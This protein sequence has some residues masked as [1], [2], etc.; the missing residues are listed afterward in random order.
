MTKYLFKNLMNSFI[1]I[2]KSLKIQIDVIRG[3]YYRE[4]LIRISKLRFGLIGIL[5]EPIL[6][7]SIWLL[8]FGARR[9]FEP[10]FSLDLIIFLSVGNIIYQIFASISRRSINSINA[11]EALFYYPRVKPFDTICARAL[12]EINTY[13]ILYLVIVLGYFYFK[14]IFFIDNLPLILIS[15]L[16][17]SIL[18]F[19]LGLILMVAGSRYFFSKEVVNVVFRPLYFISGTLFSLASLPQWIKPWLSWNPLL[20]AIELSRKGFSEL[21][22]LDPLISFSYLLKSSIIILFLGLFTYIKNQRILQ[23]K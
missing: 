23:T 13:G 4:L 6:L 12:L 2:K 15:Y 19:G 10:V 8:L 16:L 22:L 7:I 5:I 1:Q 21:Y 11:N 3:L 18:S 9:G 17:I 14:N 20:H